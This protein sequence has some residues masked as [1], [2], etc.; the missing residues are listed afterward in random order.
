MGGNSKEVVMSRE[1]ASRVFLATVVLL[2]LNCGGSEHQRDEKYYLVSTNTKLPYWQMAANGL[3]RAAAQLHV[4]AEMVGPDTYDP[5]GEREAFERILAGKP[6]GILVS[7]ADP[8][9][10]TPAIDTAITQGVPVITIDSDAPASKRLMFIGTD[11]RE[12]GRTAGRIAAKALGGKGS[13]LFFTMPE[14][15]NLKERLNGYLD[16]FSTTPDIHIAEIVDIKGDA[17]VAFDR[18][19]D[20][21]ERGSHAVDAFLCLE[22]SACAEVAEVLSR[23]YVKNKVVIAMDTD[24]PTLEWIQKG[25]I[26][27]TVAQ[28]PYT[29]AF[30][31]LKNLDDLHHRKPASL[32]INFARDSRSPIP[33]YVNTGATLIDKSNVEAF[34][35]A[36]NEAKK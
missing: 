31:G 18:T 8:V 29:M 13:V 26:A 11:N 32:Q 16:A 36:E 14:Q 28:K 4:N 3:L 30:Y 5:K 34:I 35:Q 15:T 19:M 23:K 22:A 9:V 1:L 24:P 33:V 12:V 2:L 21:V 17:R 6:R 25:V 27:A 20:L 10:I 7:A